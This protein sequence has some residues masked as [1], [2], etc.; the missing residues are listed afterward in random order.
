VTLPSGQRIAEAIEATWPAASRK[1]AQ[2]IIVREGLGGGSRVSSASADKIPTA[3]AVVAAEAAMQALGQKRLFWIRDGDEA[4]DSMLDARGYEVMDQVAL[5]AVPTDAIPAPLRAHGTAFADRPLA[6]MAE[7]W[8]NGYIDAAR[9]A[10]MARVKGDK[11]YILTRDGQRPAG[12][13]FL[14]QDRDVAILNG[15]EI[16]PEFRRKGLARELICHAARW[17]RARDIPTLGLAVTKANAPA[18]ALYASLGM[19]IVGGY[20]YRRRQD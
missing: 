9:L 14:A 15:L 2:G 11:T 19:T 12:V 20:H 18:N 5:Y 8:A 10:V 13:G 1:D 16:G 7:I 4:L 6:I 3:S 17:A